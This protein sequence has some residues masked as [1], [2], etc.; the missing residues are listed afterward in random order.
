MQKNGHWLRAVRVASAVM[1]N[2]K[3][4]QWAE[5]L[6]PELQDHFDF[7]GEELVRYDVSQHRYNKSPEKHKAALVW[8]DENRRKPERREKATF[9]LVA[10]SVVLS[11]VGI[12]VA[13][14]ASI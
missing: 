14:G 7:V 11:A 5:H 8:L 4:K 6:T 2:Q 13:M 9:W 1:S 12:G 10:I 3:R